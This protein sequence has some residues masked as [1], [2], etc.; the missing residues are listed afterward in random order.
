[1]LKAVPLTGK[2]QENY[3]KRAVARRWRDVCGKVVTPS[4]EIYWGDLPLIYWGN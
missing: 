1:M 4:L 3:E 2:F